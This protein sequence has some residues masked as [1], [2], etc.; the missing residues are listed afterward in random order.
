M[1]LNH[2]EFAICCIEH[3]F[4]SKKAFHA[5]QREIVDA[6]RTPIRV[7]ING[8]TMGGYANKLYSMLSS[9]VVAL[10]TDSALVVRWHHIDHYIEEPFDSAFAN[11][12]SL[13]HDFNA[14]Y[15]TDTITTIHSQQGWKRHKDL[16]TLTRTFLSPSH[17]R[18]LYNEYDP[19]FFEVC[20]NPI[21]YAK[22]EHY[23]LVSAATVDDALTK[24]H[25]TARFTDDQKLNSVLQ[26]G[27]EVGGHLLNKLWIPKLSLRTRIESYYQR[28]FRDHY[29]IG[30]QLRYHY[31][32]DATDTQA[33]ISCARQLEND[34]IASLGSKFNQTYKGFKWFMTSDNETILQRLVEEHAEKT[35]VATEMIGHVDDM[36][37]EKPDA[38]PRTIIDVEL[39]SRCEN[40]VI[41]GGSTFGFVA[42]MKSFKKPYYVNGRSNMSKCQLHEHSK[43]SITDTGFAVF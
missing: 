18:F 12:T 21:Y 39:L 26:I 28:E 3:N 11:F 10:L 14:N 2:Y 22:L 5:I 36:G 41:T 38:Y 4:V 25:K 40:I 30:I 37:R 29:V 6:K 24:L 43:P 42:A 35:I 19:F 33:M 23:Q 7:S 32:D 13:D 8:Y 27:F 1:S 9:L 17:N 34:V 15:K 20:S 16:K 31:L